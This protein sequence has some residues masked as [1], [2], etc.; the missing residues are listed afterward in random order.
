MLFHSN[1]HRIYYLILHYFSLFQVI[2][3]NVKKHATILSWNR[4]SLVLLRQYRPCLY[5]RHHQRLRRL[6][7]V[8][9]QE[10]L[11][12]KVMLVLCRLYRH[13]DAETYKNRD[14]QF[15]TLYTRL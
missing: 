6:A 5:H 2:H 12:I 13:R 9:A 11:A 1:F 14:L 10:M 3:L 7:K 8:I 4:A 15:S